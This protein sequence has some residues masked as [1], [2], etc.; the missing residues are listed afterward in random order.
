MSALKRAFLW[1]CIKSCGSTIWLKDW[2]F[3]A[4]NWVRAHSR[5]GGHQ[6]GVPHDSGQLPAP[7]RSPH[8]RPVLP[9]WECRVLFWGPGA[10]RGGEQWER[11]L[12][13]RPGASA[14]HPAEELDRTRQ[15]AG[16]PGA[17]CQSWLHRPPKTRIPRHPVHPGRRYWQSR[18]TADKL[19][20]AFAHPLPFKFSTVVAV[21]ATRPSFHPALFPG[22]PF[23]VIIA[24]RDHS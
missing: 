7:L 19:A 8:P 24:S 1:F 17:D 14:E 23:P 15:R 16:V 18:A 12:A 5:P 2:P 10:R 20:D 3:S 13:V 21:W 22:F 6:V 4:L 9:P 11:G